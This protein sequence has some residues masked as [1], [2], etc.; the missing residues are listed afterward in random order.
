MAESFQFELVSPERLLVSEAVTAV[1]APG[2]EGYMTV[3]ARHAPLMTTLKAGVVV[4]TLASGQE[5]RFFVRGG[6]ADVSNAGFTLL[7]ERAV[8]VE[9][10]NAADLDAQIRDAEEDVTDAKT[11]E[12]KTRAENLLAEL[13]DSR[14]AVGL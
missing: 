7:A 9:E 8:P 10:L 6:F 12:S 11:P 3:M 4:A 5:R 1:L 14:A 2:T 13:R